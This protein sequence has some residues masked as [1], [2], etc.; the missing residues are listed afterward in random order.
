MSDSPSLLRVQ[1][2]QFGSGEDYHHIRDEHTPKLQLMATHHTHIGGL[3]DS[4]SLSLE[5]ES[6][7][8]KC[9]LVE[10]INCAE[11]AFQLSHL[12]YARLYAHRWSTSK[13][14]SMHFLKDYITF[15]YVL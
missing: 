12:L 8:G 4:H 14:T 2:L 1:F 3:C 9:I 11:N 15:E 10:H 6:W 13:V 5:L 7:V